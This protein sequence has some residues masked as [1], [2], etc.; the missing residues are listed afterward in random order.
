MGG[1]GR[2]RFRR[3]M[4]AWTGTMWRP[5]KTHRLQMSLI[6]SQSNCCRSSREFHWLLGERKTRA[7]SLSS[8]RSYVTLV[9]QDWEFSNGVNRNTR[10]RWCWRKHT[11]SA[12]IVNASQIQSN[13]VCATRLLSDFTAP[14]SATHVF[15][16]R[17]GFTQS[18]ERACLMW[19]HTGYSVMTIT[20]TQ[21]VI[22]IMRLVPAYAEA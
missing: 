15:L 9:R 18:Q 22:L 3:W 16:K 19:K 8:C 13:P 11:L 10:S 5:Y 4:I 14:G 17:K 7:P 1:W 21:L 20:Y 6:K 2:R 12:C